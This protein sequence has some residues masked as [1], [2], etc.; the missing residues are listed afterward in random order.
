MSQ[1]FVSLLC[2]GAR[3]RRV[4]GFGSILFSGVSCSQRRALIHSRHV[5]LRC[6]DLLRGIGDAPSRTRERA[7]TGL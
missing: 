5:F 2:G 3:W 1:G 7:I 4:L 6:N